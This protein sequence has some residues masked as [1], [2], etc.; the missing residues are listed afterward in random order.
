[1]S[2]DDGGTFGDLLRRF[3]L[4]A[5]LSQEALAERAGISVDAV[6]ALER[7][8]R[9]TPRPDT[10][11]RL[12]IALGL[13]DAERSL[14]AQAAMAAVRAAATASSRASHLP[15]PVGPLIGRG[16]VLS[17]VIRLLRSPGS[18]LITL[19]GPGGVGKTRLALAAA[20]AAQFD[21]ADGTAF[22]SLAPLADAQLVAPT[23]AQAL[24]LPGAGRR[25]PAGRL[26]SYL[27]DRD[28]LLLLDSFE[29][30]LPAAP[31]VAELIARCPALS[32]V[33]TSRAPLRLRAEEHLRVPPLAVPPAG[34]TRLP[35]LAAYPAIKLFAARA[36]AVRPDFAIRTAQAAQ[37]AAEVCRRLDGLPLAIELAAARIG[38][39]TPA[40]LAG[41]L[42]AGLDVLRDGPRDLPSRQRTL[43]A[44]IDWSHSLLPEPSRLLFARMAAF[45]G[46]S[47]AESL[48]AVGGPG[49][50]GP[51]EALIEHSLVQAYETQ[52]ERRFGMLETIQQYACERL[53]AIGEAA[54]TRRRHAHYFLALAE[55]AE[56]ALQGSGQLSWLSRL[57]TE[58]D[59]I[60]AAL[61]WAR[62]HSEWE[63]GLRLASALWW[64]WSYHGSLRT[65]RQW[66]QELLAACAGRAPAA[67]CARAQAV[68]GWLSMHQ[69]FTD[70]ARQQ[71]EDSL[72]Q[73]EQCGAAWTAAF[74][75]TGIGAS[76]VWAHDP[77]RAHHQALLEDARD[78]WQRLDDPC[79]LLF[80]IANLGALALSERD[81]PRARPL[82]LS[83]LE[84][85]RGTGAPYS[86]GYASELLGMLALAEKDT[87]EAAVQF[88]VS[89][90]HSH[91]VGDPFIMSYSLIGL[92]AVAG[93]AGEPE[94][95]AR[96]L[97][98]A[99]HLRTI[100]DSPVLNSQQGARLADV[101][102]I[103]SC[104]GPDRFNTL[105]AAGRTLPL[106]EVIA[107]ELDS[108]T[109]A[110][111]GDH[112]RLPSL[113]RFAKPGRRQLVA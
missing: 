54:Q 102:A 113:P 51:L 55:A 44:T 28:M 23:V 12:T 17:A 7:R 72:V 67:V 91:A 45:H 27:A 95:A 64:F 35:E 13:R 29:H 47:S 6:A 63:T 53:L 62:D 26:F 22:V 66:L 75:L 106:S 103:R 76:G 40:G 30:L 65:G 109:A 110:G 8:R 96:L 61:R 68:A 82:L 5:G 105:T 81:L 52:G 99:E 11:R 57:D 90:R 38:V 37:G 84:V 1:M 78:R 83:C 87:S 36:K 43:R 97:G 56:P 79:G 31:L 93:A 77:D 15:V 80:A 107:A 89:L 74:A 19:T 34:E 46:G 49:V 59:N 60:E 104:L 20:E 21:H 33:V 41:Q 69:G 9:H 101:D 98:A 25:P 50:L 39:L 14:L 100:I 70:H 4:T 3:R 18:R 42:A 24:G 73:A 94:R 108:N 16:E 71:L 86:I 10:L 112:H 85:A 48:T 32:V 88:S 92:A 111:T 58:R 2:G